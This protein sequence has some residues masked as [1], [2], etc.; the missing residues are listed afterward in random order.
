MPTFIMDG[1]EVSAQK[2]FDLDPTRVRFITILKDA[3]ATAI[4]GSRAA[5][6]VVVIETEL[7]KAGKLQL[8]YNWSMR[9]VRGC[10]KQKIVVPNMRIII[11]LLIIK[12]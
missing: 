10:I 6:G 3:A 4:Y 5:N 7:P 2:V 1:F 11:W 8:S 9:F 12:F